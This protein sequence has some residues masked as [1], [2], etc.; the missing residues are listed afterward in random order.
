[1]HSSR[2]MGTVIICHLAE[3]LTDI[4]QPHKKHNLGRPNVGAFL[5]GSEVEI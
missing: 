4:C 5:V 2:H 3:H 1:M